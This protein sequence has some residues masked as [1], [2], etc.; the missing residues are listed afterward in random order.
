MTFLFFCFIFA[1]FGLN[2]A[3]SNPMRCTEIS[4]NSFQYGSGEY[5]NNLIMSATFKL[6]YVENQTNIIQV[7][8]IIAWD[9]NEK[10]PASQICADIL[11]NCT[12][13]FSTPFNI[14][15]IDNN[16]GLWADFIENN[17]MFE[18]DL[19]FWYGF[20]EEGNINHPDGTL[21]SIDN[22]CIV[23]EFDGSKMVQCCN[24]FEPVPK[25]PAGN[26]PK[27]KTF[28][29]RVSIL[30]VNDNYSINATASLTLMIFDDNSVVTTDFNFTEN[31]IFAYDLNEC[32]GIESNEQGCYLPYVDYKAM[33][34]VFIEPPSTIEPTIGKWIIRDNVMMSSE[35]VPITAKNNCQYYNE[36][37]DEDQLL[38]S[39][40]CCQ[41]F[42]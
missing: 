40:F 5:D 20:V 16:F 25:A 21:F 1:F 28:K 26:F 10:K 8:D 36:P 39:Q 7:S 13:D 11:S 12:S 32:G 23:N 17:G 41:E 18:E 38:S 42:A 31:V 6:F 3:A 22:A 34:S 2:S 35:G 37:L 4:V 14:T 9:F 29:S 27:C 15:V 33:L 30:N 19:T 24:S